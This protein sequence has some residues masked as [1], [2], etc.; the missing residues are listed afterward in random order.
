[1]TLPADDLLIGASGIEQSYA[2]ATLNITTS[3]TGAL[4]LGDP[5]PNKTDGYPE[6]RI[7]SLY[8]QADE[9]IVERCQDRSCCPGS[10]NLGNDP[11]LVP[12]L[13]LGDA[14]KGAQGTETKAKNW[15]RTLP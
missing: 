14:T 2:V 5:P 1:M 6:N 9:R 4:S 11:E 3:K 8:R 15:L 7:V 10:R 12:Y 13:C